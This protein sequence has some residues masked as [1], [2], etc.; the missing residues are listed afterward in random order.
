MINF[1][2]HIEKPAKKIAL[3]S[4]TLIQQGSIN[5]LKQL[6]EKP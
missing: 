6:K 3:N 2:N 4:R 5:V 1:L